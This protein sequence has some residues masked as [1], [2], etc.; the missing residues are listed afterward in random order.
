[1]TDYT[2]RHLI[3]AAIR[4]DVWE[5]FS[6]LNKATF[7]N[8][9]GPQLSLEVFTVAS[10]GAGCLHCQAHGAYGL[11]LMDV[12]TDRIQELWSF[13]HSDSFSEADRAALRF[14]LAAAKAPN[15]VTPRHHREM[16]KYYSD[17]EIADILSIVCVAG[18]LNRW[19]DSLATVTDQESID[20]AK[21]NLST[22]GWSTG[23]HRGDAAEQRQ[24]HPATMWRQGKDPL[25]RN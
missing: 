7:A 3:E 9:L 11:A 22:V 8:D 17:K 13:E 19:N 5:A 24:A 21:D 10:Q 14:A 20:W 4:P 23:K 6:Q 15:E 1:M 2:D 12:D 16:R 18:W 25:Q